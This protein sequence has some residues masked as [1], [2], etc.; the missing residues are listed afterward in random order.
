[1]QPETPLLPVLPPKQDFINP[2]E[3]FK[4]PCSF[5]QA[6]SLLPIRHL[7]VLEVHAE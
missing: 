7:M 2:I 3:H 4:V 5:D 1:M 6:T